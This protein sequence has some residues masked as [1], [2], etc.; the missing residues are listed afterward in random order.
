MQDKKFWGDNMRRV[1]LFILVLSIVSLTAQ[2]N[3]RYINV[4]GTSELTLP[5]DQINFNIRIVIVDESVEKSKETNDRYL[6]ELLNILKNTGIHSD[7]ISVSPL[8]LGKHYESK[9]REKIHKGF[10]TKV[11]VL[12]LLKDLSRYYELTN[13]LASSDYYEI[14]NA[15]YNISDY[16]EQHKLAYKEALRAAKEKAEYMAETLGLEVNKVLEIEESGL[17]QTYPNPF[18]TAVRGESQGG[19][20][21]GKVIIKRSVRVKFAIN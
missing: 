8:T 16:E 9:D 19:D 21:S 15:N 20:I 5:A 14:V 4:N 13:K 11:N 12:F 2:E 6:N 1:A 10:Y 18:N 7:D 17:I 3:E